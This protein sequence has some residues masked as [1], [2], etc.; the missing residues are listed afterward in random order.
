M[1]RDKAKVKWCLSLNRTKD[2]L[3]IERRQMWS[4]DK[5]YTKV[6]KGKSGNP[7]LDEA[8]PFD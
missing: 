3:N 6:Y 1:E 5:R 8:F 4:I 2:C 7:V